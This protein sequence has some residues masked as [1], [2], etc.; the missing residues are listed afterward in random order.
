MHVLVRPSVRRLGGTLALALLVG[1]GTLAGCSGAAPGQGDRISIAAGGTGGVYFVYGGGLANLITEHVEGYEATS[2]TTSASVDNMLLVGEQSSDV[3]FAL[4]DAAVDGVNGEGA[5]EEPVPAR[6][7]AQLYVSPVQIVAGAGSGI[8]SV[9]D[10]RGR[11]VSVGAPNSATEVL[12][13]RI[14]E[15]AGLDPDADIERAQLSVAESA[16][17]LG[18]GTVDAFFWGGG[19][20]TGAVTDLATSTDI[21]LVPSAEYLDALDEEYPEVYTESAI[22]GGTYEGVEEDV[23]ALSARNFLMVHE[24][25]DEELAYQ[26]TKLLFDRRD[27]LIEVHPE[28]ENLNI[29]DAQD[30]AP[31][32]FHPGAQR[33]YDEQG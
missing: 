12:A 24:E 33:Y 7:L 29:E 31:L 11:R 2:E 25:M 14:L 20:P 32:E 9:E 26:I 3:A 4:A 16:D 10:L 6:A 28:A 8:E 5:F 30:I 1:V 27:E 22:P 13:D 21:T 18:D 15:A 19:V 17:A 23:P